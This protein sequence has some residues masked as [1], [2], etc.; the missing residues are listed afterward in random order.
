M[1]DFQ[2]LTR[3]IVKHALDDTRDLQSKLGFCL[4]EL[5]SAAAATYMHGDLF[6]FGPLIHHAS[7]PLLG[8]RYLPTCLLGLR[9]LTNLDASDLDL[10]FSRLL[11]SSATALIGLL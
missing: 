1:P 2:R 4:S 8:G 11:S 7:S 10:D 6:L 9:S 3:L 5:V